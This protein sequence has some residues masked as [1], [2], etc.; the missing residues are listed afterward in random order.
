MTVLSGRVAGVVGKK[1]KSR[2]DPHSG[3]VPSHLILKLYECPP[4]LSGPKQGTC[5]PCRSRVSSALKARSEGTMGISCLE[6]I[7]MLDPSSGP[8]VV[9]GQV[10][11]GVQCLYPKARA[12]Y[13][14]Q[15]RSPT[16]GHHRSWLW[17]HTTPCHR[18]GRRW[19]SSHTCCP[20]K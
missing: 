2:A 8:Q 16:S 20:G 6:T 9:P 4:K 10:W 14:G 5:L 19:C 3:S 11:R 7:S 15:D 18:C 17:S 12:S 1:C 13:L